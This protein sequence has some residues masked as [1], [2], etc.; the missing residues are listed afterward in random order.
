[1]EQFASTR[2][3]KRWKEEARNESLTSVRSHFS[4]LLRCQFLSFPW[5]DP[6]CPPPHTIQYYLLLPSVER[7]QQSF[8]L[9]SGQRN[10]HL[11]P[12]IRTVRTGRVLPHL[13]AALQYLVLQLRLKIKRFLKE[14]QKQYVP[15]SSSTIYVNK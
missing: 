8:M 10:A 3:K 13:K 15:S 1:M 11:K 14:P 7:G 4:S 5:C 12:V 2:N 6:S 9:E